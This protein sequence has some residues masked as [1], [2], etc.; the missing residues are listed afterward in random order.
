VSNEFDIIYLENRWGYKSGPGS[1]PEQ[2]KVWID[3]VNSFLKQEDI[4]TIIDVGCGDWRLGQ[5]YNLEDK[6]YTGI[7]ISSVIL[8]ETMAHATDN[9]KFIHGD[10]DS[11][12]IE[13]VDLIIIKDVLQ[14]LPNSKIVSIIDKIKTNAR[15]ALFCDMYIKVNDR[16]LNSDIPMGRARPIDLS[17]KP[18]SFDFEK[19]ERYNGKQISLYRN[20][21]FE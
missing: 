18:F 13:P 17:E 6:V 21:S 19:I 2:A 12:E 9:V 4:K 15:Y 16:E 11:L 8:D 14:H 20:E 5:N 1:E 10:F 7:D 3:I